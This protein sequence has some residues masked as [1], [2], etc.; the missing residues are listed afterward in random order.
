MVRKGIKFKIKFKRKTY[1]P[2][3]KLSIE[4]PREIYFVKKHQSLVL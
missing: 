2:F 1:L 4:K 3:L